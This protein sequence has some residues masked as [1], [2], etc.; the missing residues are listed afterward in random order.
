[1]AEET[2]VE[3]KTVEAA[4]AAAEVKEE[5]KPNPL[6]R[7]VEFLLDRKEV[8]KQV[9]KGLRERGKK[10]R[11]HGFRPGK[12][13]A[14]MVAAAYGRE[15]EYDVIN[16]LAID[17]YIKK[18][19][20]GK[21]RVS[22]MPDIAPT[23]GAPADADKI[24]FTATFE[25][26]PEVTVPDVKDVEVTK[27]E[28]E[29]TDENV[30]KTIDVMRKQRATYNPT[31]KAAADTDE[32]TVDF[33]GTLDG[34]AFA[35]GTASDYK[36]ILGAGRMLAEFENGIRGMKP[37]ETKTFPVTFPENY[38]SKE[39]A[40]KTVEFEATLKAVG[41]EVLPALDDEFAKSLQIESFEKMKN[42]VKDNLQREVE[43][44]LQART[45]QSAMSAL[46][47]VS[48]FPLPHAAVEEQRQ[49]LIHD[50][51]EKMKL[52]GIKLQPQDIPASAMLQEATQRV[53]LGLEISTLVEKEN[54]Q[55]TDEQ[56]KALAENIAKSYEDPKEVVDWYIN[57]P[58]HK[59]ELAAVATENNVVDWVLKNAKVKNEKIPFENLMADRA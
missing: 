52:Q 51:V 12:A 16:K 4:E 21:Y 11:F 6:E 53:R 38:P 36:F 35:G 34:E 46:L 26:F 58:Q 40:G 24:S 3:D 41:E 33:K 42:D 9:A 47:S 44:R 32:V 31:E 39:L 17:E 29:L 14:A 22:G 49:A 5:V 54:L 23:E 13:P 48:D 43:A 1:M 57:N 2:K 7:K 15:V 55:G 56:V 30:N 59:A 27:Y 19:E 18:I 28:C 25:V 50:A 45:K 8:E 37:G 20:E 10:A